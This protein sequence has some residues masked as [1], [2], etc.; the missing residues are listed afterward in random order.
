MS[1]P[2]ADLLQDVLA[3]DTPGPVISG[4]CIDSRT[5]QGGDLFLAVPGSRGGHGLEFAEAALAAGAAAVLVDCRGLS[6]AQQ[7]EIAARRNYYLLP[8][9]T[10]E[11]MAQ[12]ADR[13]F[14]QPAR[15]LRL[16]GV[17]G[18][19]G[20][21]SVTWLLAQAGLLAGHESGVIGTLG[22]GAW[23]RLAPGRHTT[24]DLPGLRGIIAGLREQ[25]VRRICMEVSSHALDQQRVAGLLFEVAILTNISRDHLDYHG[26]MEAYGQA[27]AS[28][29]ESGRCRKAVLP[30]NDALGSELAGSLRAE[31]RA[32]LTTGIDCQADVVANDLVLDASGSRF[33]LKLK[34]EGHPVSSHLLGLF[35]VENLLLVAAALIHEGLAPEAVASLLGRLEAP[36]GR[37]QIVPAAEGQPRVV[38]DYAH[39]PDALEQVLSSLRPLVSGRLVVLFG[40]GGKRDAGKRAPMGQAA[41][42]WADAVILT[43]DNS[44][45]EDVMAICQQIAAGVPEAVQCQ[46]QPER[47]KA[48]AA[49]IAEAGADDLVLLAGKGHETSMDRG[50]E[51]LDFDDV[52]HARQA[53]QQRGV[54]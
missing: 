1:M 53:L 34:G 52:I 33:T 26:S 9:L 41:A 51:V 30:I 47:S 49:A 18:T 32:V 43:E 35:N 7:R 4:L 3:M 20:K 14:G 40:C 17:T 46:I 8:D 16:I 25:G 48:I 12:L 2:L 13:F 24:P 45:G 31:G 39:T 15:D 44:R 21:T 37:L 50:S 19:N 42:R 27:K 10:P 5:V 29:F 38:V 54:A 28:L 23:P 11:R 36:P 6:Q 22:N